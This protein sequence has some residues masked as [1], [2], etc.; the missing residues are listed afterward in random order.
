MY[1][2]SKGNW[3]QD[4]QELSVIAS[5][6]FCN[7]KLFKKIK[8]IFQNEKLKKMF[9]SHCIQRIN[10]LNLWK[11]F[12]AIYKKKTNSTIFENE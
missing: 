12:L 1:N 9:R 2:I 4:I 7:L 3:M 6:F 5:Q 8:S 10:L 11:E